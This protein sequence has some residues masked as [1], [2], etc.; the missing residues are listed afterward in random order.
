MSFVSYAQNFEDV[1]L[2]RALKHI[3]KGVYIDIGAQDPVTDSVSMGFYELGWRGISVEPNNFYANALRR[4]RPDE[5]VIETIVAHHDGKARLYE[6]H[7]TGL[8]TVDAD[9]AAYYQAQGFACSQRECQSITLEH[10]FRH[11]CRP[12]IHWMKIDVEGHEAE[13]LRGWGQAPHRPWIVV[14]ESVSPQENKF[15]HEEW[16]KELTTRDYKFTHFDGLNRFYVHKDHHEC[17]SALSLPPNI[18]D[19]FR[20]NERQPH[21]FASRI[22]AKCERHLVEKNQAIA[23]LTSQLDA[24]KHSR[25]WRLTRPLRGLRRLMSWCS[26]SKCI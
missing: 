26:E 5:E 20:L 10:L 4:A 2:W 16:E 7:G 12:D 11:H 22:T 14:I 1:M 9:L 13:V 3:D 21:L 18:F 19:D 6:F 15:T 17:V 8:S 24:I 25:S 23:S